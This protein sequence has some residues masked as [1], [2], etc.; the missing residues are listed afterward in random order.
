[1]IVCFRSPSTIH[2]ARRRTGQAGASIPHK[3]KVMHGGWSFIRYRG[4]KRTTQNREGAVEKLEIVF[5]PLPGE[6]LTRFLTD[7]VLNVN[8]ARTGI[9]T[10]HPVGFFLRNARGEWLGGLTGYV[11][12]GWFHVNFLWVSEPLRGQGHGGRLMDTAEAFAIERGASAATLETHSFGAEHFY[13]KR[14]YTVFGHLDNYPPGHTKLFL[15]KQLNA[16]TG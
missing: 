14:G 10:W 5:E 11:W 7:N 16:S 1:M 12:G 3:F 2:H 9:S 6:A 4:T 15:R 8:M 13:L